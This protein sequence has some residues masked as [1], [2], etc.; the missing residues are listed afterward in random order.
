MLSQS[1]LCGKDV[2]DSREVQGNV[3][4]QEQ[5]STVNTVVS[6]SAEI[7]KD[8]AD[9]LDYYDIP[10]EWFNLDNGN[11]NETFGLKKTYDKSQD[12]H[13]KIYDNFVDKETSDK[14]INEY[15]ERYP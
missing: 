15:V 13:H 1:T 10:Y 11:Y 5:Q 3:Q 7:E 4:T 8:I 2:Q 12:P 14:W 6:E 9:L